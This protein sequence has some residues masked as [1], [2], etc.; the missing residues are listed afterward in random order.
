MAK[1]LSLADRER[2]RAEVHEIVVALGSPREKVKKRLAC[3]HEDYVLPSIDPQ[4]A[5]C[6]C[7]VRDKGVQPQPE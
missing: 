1:R 2:I 5:I 7:C 3:G 6:W 4:H